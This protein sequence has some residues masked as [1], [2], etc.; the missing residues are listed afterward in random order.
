MLVVKA[1]YEGSDRQTLVEAV[2]TN[3]KFLYLDKIYCAE[4]SKKDVMY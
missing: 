3:V 2:R 4:K 1:L